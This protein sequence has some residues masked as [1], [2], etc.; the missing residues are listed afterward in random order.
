MGR[1]KEEPA[2]I[3]LG[4]T[5]PSDIQVTWDPERGSNSRVQSRLGI[6]NQPGPHLPCCHPTNHKFLM[7]SRCHSKV[8]HLGHSK[9]LF[10]SRVKELAL[11][12]HSLLCA[13][14]KNKSL[15]FINIC[16]PPRPLVAGTQRTQARSPGLAL[17]H[18]QAAAGCCLLSQVTHP[19]RRLSGGAALV[20]PPAPGMRWLLSVQGLLKQNP[21]VGSMFYSSFF[22]KLTRF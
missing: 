6:P 12:S 3:S 4:P 15:P 7:N 19:G 13:F 5:L 21:R 16:P 14:C 17:Q 8:S 10:K 18:V 9:L 2:L 20:S 11:N 22:S 1:E